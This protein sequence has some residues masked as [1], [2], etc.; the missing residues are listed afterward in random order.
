MRLSIDAHGLI[1]KGLPSQTV[2]VFV[3][4]VAVGQIRFDDVQNRGWRTLAVPL[5]ALTQGRQAFLDVSFKIE[6]PVRPADLGMS[7]DYREIGMGLIAMR[8]DA[9][10]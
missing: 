1:G 9:E 8:L 10:P 5:T 6:Q 3:N 2:T 7:E 4:D